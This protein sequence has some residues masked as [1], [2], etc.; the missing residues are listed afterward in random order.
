MYTSGSPF[1]A[2]VV[3]VPL[4]VPAIQQSMFVCGGVWMAVQHL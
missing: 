2:Q 3:S 4:Y 1:C